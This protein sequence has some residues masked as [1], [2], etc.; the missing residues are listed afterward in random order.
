MIEDQ[1]TVGLHFAQPE[2]A[3]F[4]TE[5]RTPGTQVKAC[6]CL[7]SAASAGSAA[8]VQPRKSS[9]TLNKSPKAAEAALF[10]QTKLIGGN[11]YAPY[12]ARKYIKELPPKLQLLQP[13][14]SPP[15]RPRGREQKQGKQRVATGAR[16]DVSSKYPRAPR[17]ALRP[18]GRYGQ[19]ALQTKRVHASARCTDS[20]QRAS[21]GESPSSRGAS[22]QGRQ[23]T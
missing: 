10:E 4:G 2:T 20:R 18:T 8:Q 23:H 22:S 13:P 12:V 6:R 19:R 5:L 7:E 16:A 15:V 11:C 9:K 17:A 1:C 3:A 14:A 21:R